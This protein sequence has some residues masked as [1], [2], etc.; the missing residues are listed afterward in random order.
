MLAYVWKDTP[1]SEVALG[2]SKNRKVPML[3]LGVT[4][5]LDHL[6]VLQF[7][8]REGRDQFRSLCD[9][10][11]FALEVSVWCREHHTHT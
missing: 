6:L 5:K 7:N 4:L 8:N 2:F 1:R 11:I 3:P 10:T 9:H